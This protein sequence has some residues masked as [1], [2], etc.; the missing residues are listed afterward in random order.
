MN[1]PTGT[2]LGPY[3][4]VGSLGSGGMG[5]VY[6]AQDLRLKRPV[7]LKLLARGSESRSG[8]SGDL[9]QEARLASQLNHPNI[10]VIYEIDEAEYEK[11]R[12]TFIAMEYVAGRTLK[13]VAAGSRLPVA[14]TLRIGREIAA[15]LA[16][17]HA[18]GV[19]HRDVKPSN[20]MVTETGRVKVL[21]F[22]LA[23]TIPLPD[24]GETTWSLPDSGAPH[25]AGAVGPVGTV[26]YMSP[27]QASG[28][29]VDARSDVF[30]LGVLLYELLA[31]R[32]PFSGET[33]VE[34][35]A[36]VLR[37][38]PAP[39]GRFNP[40]VG[41]DLE[42]VLARMLEKDRDRRYPDMGSVSGDLES[43]ERGLRPPGAPAT[44]RAIAVLAFDNITGNAE[45][46]WLGTGIAET[47]TVGLK[48]VAGVDVISRERIHELV[49]KLRTQTE[50]RGENLLA[51]VGRELSARWV[52]GGGYQRSGEMLRVT[53][54]VVEADT[55]TAVRT[56][57]ID[58]PLGDIFAIQDRLVA[59]LC[60]ELRLALTPGRREEDDT[61]V[62]EAYEAFA[63]GMINLRGE[64]RESLDRAIY[65]FEK[66]IDL[67]PSYARAHLRLGETYDVKGNYLAMPEMLERATASYRRVIALKP[68][69]AEA[70]R[71]LGST[72]VALGKD[73]EGIAAIERALALD[74]A[75]AGVHGSLG[76]AQFIAKGDFLAA[77]REFERA[78]ELNPEAGWYALQL[79]HCAALLGDFPKAEK[80]ARRAAALQEEF[81]SGREGALI[82]GAYTR[83]GQIAAL[84]GRYEAALAEYEREFEFLRRVDHALKD[85]HLIELHTRIG[86]AEK[87]LGRL[88]EAAESLELA[89]AG[90]ERRAAAGADEPFTRYYAACAWALAG[91]QEKAIDALERAA[92]VRPRLMLARARIDPDF[93]SVR[94]HPRFRALFGNAAA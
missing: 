38:D 27:E 21:D 8:S 55:G 6:R 83:L 64:S 10:A 36:A 62:V 70:W 80:A 85:R 67:D 66:A 72:L 23:M 90:F 31:G 11:E 82:V 42:R 84:Q 68:E 25:P 54:R 28:R 35:L 88:E 77:S 79:A 30:S 22:G 13:D 58:G 12:Y 24:D 94:E 51:R 37:G 48:N 3:E 49:R 17:A 92:A 18:R 15:A 46:D 78:L 34:V 19:I 87:R 86:S 26:A 52:V 60:A 65:F 7:A 43:I 61:H 81:L 33:V 40:E 50:E 4:I 32:P 89:I 57:K 69:M 39:A 41:A 75:E 63:K 44:S 47:V 71:E 1:L 9:L 29:E 2:R 56:V 91:E 20:V 76:R 59:E 74:P 45:D 53:S 16:E 14:E 73:D 5:E 93:E